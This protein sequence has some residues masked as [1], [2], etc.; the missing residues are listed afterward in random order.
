MQEWRT[1]DFKGADEVKVEWDQEG[2]M[3]S[4]SVTIA[5]GQGI[6]PTIV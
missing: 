6:M 4:W 1:L 3:D 2:V 5:E